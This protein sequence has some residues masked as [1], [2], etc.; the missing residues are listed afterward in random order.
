MMALFFFT[1]AAFI[2]TQLSRETLVDSTIAGRDLNKVQSYYSAKAGL[3]IA[4]LRIK[5]YQIAKSK[6]SGNP[7]T[8]AIES[9]L[10]MIWQFPLPW[11]LPIPEDASLILKDQNDSVLDESLIKNL[12]FYHE[13]TNTANKIDINN[14]GSPIEGIAEKTKVSLMRAFEQALLN[15]D[16]LSDEHSLDTIEEVLNNI[17]DWIDTDQEA[18]S[19]GSEQSLYP[20]EDQKGYP[21]NSSLMT[22]SE[23]N[24]IAKMDDFIFAYL[25]RL[26][27]INGSFGIDVNSADKEMLMSLDSQ[28]DEDTADEFIEKR[29]EFHANG[30]Q[31]DEGTFDTILS[32]LGFNNI[33]EIHNSGVPIIYSPIS[34]YT[35]KSSGTVGSTETTITAR[36]LD[37]SQLKKVLTEAINSQSQNK[38]TSG[39]GSGGQTGGNTKS[40]G[41]NQS[42]A[43][44]QTKVEPPKGKPKLIDLIVD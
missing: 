19:G 20:Y 34:S 12:T 29:N 4:L 3:E 36:V 40:S 42:G 22:F 2:V 9:Q 27:T 43:S 13:I 31:L 23:L 6:I 25:E 1:I 39:A 44:S 35:I 5:A 15:D 24:L 7:N 33:D 30:A 41:Q 26:T 21:R 11:P 37:V 10:D 16:A 8:A 28:F 32:D 17:A 38:N 18:K 14:L